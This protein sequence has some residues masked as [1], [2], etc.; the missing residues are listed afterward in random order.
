MLKEV[1]ILY[2]YAS[3]AVYGALSWLNTTT[4]GYTLHPLQQVHLWLLWEQGDHKVMESRVC[5]GELAEIGEM[6]SI[7]H[8]QAQVHS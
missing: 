2:V 8:L 1:N 4:K 6:D 7:V 5:V 3:K